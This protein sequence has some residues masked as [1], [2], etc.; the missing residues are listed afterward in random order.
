M[1]MD[2]MEEKH[3]VEPVTKATKAKKEKAVKAVKEPK[4]KAVKAVK[5][6]KEKPKQC[7]VPSR[8]SKVE[9][10]RWA[11]HVYE[12][13]T[14]AKVEIT[15]EIIDLYNH[16]VN[17]LKKFNM[18]TGC[19]PKQIRYDYGICLEL[20]QYSLRGTY[21]HFDHSVSSVEKETAY[22]EIMTAYQPLFDLI[23]DIVVP[24]MK[25]QH[26][27][28]ITAK[29]LEYKKKLLVKA[30]DDMERLMAEHAHRMKHL[31]KYATGIEEEIKK[32]E[33]DCI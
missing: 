19:P 6:K 17:T 16:L 27:K 15:D 10:I 14:E 31:H 24:F 3:E 5:P 8:N 21:I 23:K 25:T 1:D 26:T 20:T 11:R 4:V 7:E 13:I 30:H 29:T 22:K 2:K 28:L 32:L 33:S 9:S 18:S 12:M